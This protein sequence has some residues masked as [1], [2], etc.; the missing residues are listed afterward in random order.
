MR[1][2]AR[3]AI[4]AMLSVAGALGVYLSL[5][6]GWS[7]APRPWSFL[8]GFAAGVLC[9]LGATLVVAGLLKRRRSQ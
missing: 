2:Q 5:T 4:G 8:L 7:E 9:G 3:L 1:T 6:L